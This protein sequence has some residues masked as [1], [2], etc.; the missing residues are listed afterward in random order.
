MPRQA[1]PPL[2]ESEHEAVVEL[3]QVAWQVLRG[4]DRL[5]ILFHRLVTRLD[6]Y[7]PLP[8][9]P[10]S[11][12]RDRRRATLADTEIDMA[13]EQL[14]AAANIYATRKP[15]SAKA[16]DAGH[17]LWCA[18]V[19]MRGRMQYQPPRI[20]PPRRGMP[21]APGVMTARPTLA[22]DRDAV[23]DRHFAG[24]LVARGAAASGWRITQAL[25]DLFMA[26]TG[27]P[28]CSSAGELIDWINSPAGTAA[29]AADGGD[30]FG[31]R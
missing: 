9:P 3:L 17:R 5:S 19:A 26:S 14:E 13:L 29:I 15:G 31:R 6:L 7:V 25:L 10:V 11:S 12:L 27:K 21:I 30:N 20:P 23:W 4:V 8:P 16:R 24:M 28:F 2:S 18:L 22:H 1:K